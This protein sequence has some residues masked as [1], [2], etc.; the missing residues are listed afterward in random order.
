M[1]VVQHVVHR[2]VVQVRDLGRVELSLF[3]LVEFALELRPPAVVEQS[4]L[5]ISGGKERRCGRRHRVGFGRWLGGRSDAVMLDGGVAVGRYRRCRC[6]CR[7]MHEPE[8]LGLAHR[9]GAL[10]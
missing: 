9:V 5:I 3:G 1:L 6:R 10:A 2:I 8:D 4:S 7:G